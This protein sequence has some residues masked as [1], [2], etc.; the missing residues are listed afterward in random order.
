MIIMYVSHTPTA[1][2]TK[3]NCVQVFPN[4][5]STKIVCSSQIRT[6][7]LKC[8]V[9]IRHVYDNT[10]LLQFPTDDNDQEKR[11]KWEREENEGEEGREKRT[12]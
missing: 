2:S 3:C 5:S 1:N 8:C 6:L 12:K 10:L 11:R 9:N 4:T 7:C